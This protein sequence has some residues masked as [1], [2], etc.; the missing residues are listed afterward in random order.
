M[1]ASYILLLCLIASWS[2]LS[3]SY[4][5]GRHVL[6][7]HTSSG[8]YVHPFRGSAKPPN[9]N[10]V[11]LH[12]GY[13]ANATWVFKAAASSGFYYIEHA[14]SGRVSSEK[15]VYTY[16]RGQKSGILIIFEVFLIL[17]FYCNILR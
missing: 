13:H 8:K 16:K 14:T 10:P 5:T 1:F 7:K 2:T 15:H 3:L 12:S 4:C 17:W 6:I 9:D 11:V